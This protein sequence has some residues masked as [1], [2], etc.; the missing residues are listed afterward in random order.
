MTS[1]EA[2]ATAFAAASI[3]RVIDWVV[4]GLTTRMRMICG[5]AF[6]TTTVHGDDDAERGANDDKREEGGDGT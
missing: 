2:E 3:V 4:L 1:V 6:Q 5:S